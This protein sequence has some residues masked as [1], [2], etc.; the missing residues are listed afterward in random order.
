MDG[1]SEDRSI[2]P[3]PRLAWAFFVAPSVPVLLMMMIMGV[4]SLASGDQWWDA[5]F[6]ALVTGAYGLALGYLP[7]FVLDVPAYLLL[8]RRFAANARNCAIAGALVAATPSILI[9]L[10]GPPGG[11]AQVGIALLQVVCAA[12]LGALAGAVFWM[13]LRPS[14]PETEGQARKSAPS[15]SRA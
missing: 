8:R 6:V 1:T 3:W 10:L 15:T 5:A 13:A 14:E 2:T 11:A 7:T 9:V 12:L 4:A